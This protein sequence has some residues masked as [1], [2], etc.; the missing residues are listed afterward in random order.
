MTSNTFIHLALGLAGLVSAAD[1]LADTADA[2][3][4]VHSDGLPA[5]LS[6]TAAPPAAGFRGRSGPGVVADAES[7]FPAQ[8][9][10][11]A[12]MAEFAARYRPMVAPSARGGDAAVP[13]SVLDSDRRFRVYPQESGYPYR[14]VGLLSFTQGSGS[15][16]CTGWLI[17]ADTVA[18]AGH[19]VHSG[20][21]G[22][23]WS[24]S[25]RFYPGRNAGSAPYGSCTAKRLSSVTGWT[26]N[27][28]ENYDYGSVKLNC[29]VGNTTGWLGRWWTTGSQVN[30]PIAI[31]GYPGDKPSATQWGG[32]GRIAASETRKTRYFVDTAG[33]Q[34]G[35][36]VIQAD[37]TGPGGCQGDCGLAIHA[38]GADS[39]GRNSATR[40]TQ[41]VNTNLQTWIDTP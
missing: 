17:S 37:G 31:V 8:K 29:T 21:T 4:S 15:Y 9:F 38:Y 32:A 22:G 13:E 10:S 34:S 7:E 14:A 35:A 24:T 2:Q 6:T 11:P 36:P 25:M 20:G 3:L 26:R 28:D 33:G 23:V 1:A 16:T 40:I 12:E 39:L 19:C 27:A 18:T 30:L 41:T 5:Q